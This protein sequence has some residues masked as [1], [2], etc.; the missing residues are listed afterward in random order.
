[1][2]KTWHLHTSHSREFTVQAKSDNEALEAFLHAHQRELEPGEHVNRRYC[3]VRSHLGL[4]I[5]DF[6]PNK[7]SNVRI[8]GKNILIFDGFL[9]SLYAPFWLLRT[10]R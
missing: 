9:P 10:A 2:T 4:R 8:S 1:M 7:P 3:C 6:E 5:S